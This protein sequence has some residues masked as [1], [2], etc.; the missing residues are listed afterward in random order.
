MSTDGCLITFEA[1]DVVRLVR[2]VKSFQYVKDPVNRRRPRVGDVATILKVYRSGT[3]GYQLECKDGRG[4][5]Q[6]VLSFPIAEIDLELVL[7]GKDG[8]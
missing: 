3:L 2:F 8:E 4:E 1:Y 7:S 5:T 6:W